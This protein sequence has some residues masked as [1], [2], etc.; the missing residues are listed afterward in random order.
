MNTNT[1]V[2]NDRYKCTYKAMDKKTR[3]GY[4]IDLKYKR[5]LLR[6]YFEYTDT[7]IRIEQIVFKQMCET[8]LNARRE[9]SKIPTK[10]L[11]IELL[12]S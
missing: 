10:Q 9:E 12:A 2:L 7:T 3:L 1:F 4:M 5:Q 6:L 8:F 11:P